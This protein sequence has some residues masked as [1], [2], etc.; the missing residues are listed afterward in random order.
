MKHGIPG[1]VALA[2]LLLLSMPSRA[3]DSQAAASGGS[4]AGSYAGL[5]AGYGW[6]SADA[7]APFDPGPGFFYNFGGSRYEFS[8]GGFFGGGAAGYNW[9]RGS[10]VTGAEAEIGYLGLRGSS[11]DPNG[12][13]TGFP[14]TTTSVKSGLFG[15]LTGRLGVAAGKALVYAKGGA[16]LL[17]AK[18]ETIDPCVAPPAGCGVETLFMSGSKTLLGWTVGAGVEWPV[19]PRWSVRAEIAYF[20]FGNID[21]VGASSGGATYFQSVDVTARAARVGVNYRF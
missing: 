4:W 5:Y 21:T 20:D 18:V 6:G 3:A 12:V 7:T 11:L 17:K 16:A 10:I 13:V 19:A 14:D 15:A 8:A 9:Q 1:A 2:A